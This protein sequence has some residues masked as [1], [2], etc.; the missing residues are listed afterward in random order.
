MRHR[1]LYE[2]FIA[3]QLRR[4]A[5]L[6]ED[7]PPGRLA[8]RVLDHHV[9]RMTRDAERGG[10]AFCDEHKRKLIERSGPL[11]Q[12]GILEA[13]GPFRR[14]ECVMDREVVAAGPA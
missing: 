1:F 3:Q 6:A 2:Y 7:H 10:R 13:E 4:L 12:I 8:L 5:A 9:D 14:Y 11:D